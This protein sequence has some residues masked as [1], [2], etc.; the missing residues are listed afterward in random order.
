MHDRY[1][2]LQF[3]SACQTPI[4]SQHFP[5]TLQD[6]LRTHTGS[7]QGI[8]ADLVTAHYLPIIASIMLHEP[9]A[10]FASL[11]NPST[12]RLASEA[13]SCLSIIL[14]VSNSGTDLSFCLAPYTSCESIPGFRPAY[15][16]KADGLEC[17]TGLGK[18]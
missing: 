16:R 14:D 3:L 7:W 10:D 17:V 1:D 11:V 13:R 12:T 8:E 6:P 9:F 2:V 4:R 5:S 15:L 18:V